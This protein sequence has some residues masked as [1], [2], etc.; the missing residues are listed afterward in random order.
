M[1][2]A[3]VGPVPPRATTHADQTTSC[4]TLHPIASSTSA[5]TPHLQRRWC[6]TACQCAGVA[7]ACAILYSARVRRRPLTRVQAAAIVTGIQSNNISACVKHFVLNVQEAERHNVSANVD[8]RTFMEL[9]APAFE[10]AVD[11]GVGCVM[12]ASLASTRN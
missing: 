11:A 9:Y 2:L 7:A 8:R 5:K 4:L 10:A 3:F 1:R 12:C 6:A